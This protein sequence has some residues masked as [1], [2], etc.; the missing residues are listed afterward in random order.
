LTGLRLA[1]RNLHRALIAFLG[2]PFGVQQI[3]LND[4]RA[5]VAYGRHFGRYGQRT[6]A[7]EHLGGQSQIASAMLFGLSD[8]NV[9]DVEAH[10]FNRLESLL[11]WAGASASQ[12]V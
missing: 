5:A 3:R 8:A 6:V 7:G 9:D 4:S 11:Q 2:R 12:A 1:G 10:P